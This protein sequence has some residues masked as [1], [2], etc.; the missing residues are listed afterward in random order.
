MQNIR[1]KR[2]YVSMYQS[3]DVDIPYCDNDFDTEKHELITRE[4]VELCN[5]NIAARLDENSKPYQASK[6]LFDLI[7]NNLGV[8]NSTD[9]DKIIQYSESI[10]EKRK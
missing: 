9:I 1:K 5:Y 3:G 2:G 6:K 10:I 7:T 8:L 4:E